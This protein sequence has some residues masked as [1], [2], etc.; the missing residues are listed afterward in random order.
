MMSNKEVKKILVV[1]DEKSLRLVLS[2]ILKNEGYDVTT[3]NDGKEALKVFRKGSF[4]LVT[5]CIMMPYPNTDGLTLLR[6]IKKISPHTPVLIISA[7]ASSKR[8]E[9]M[10]EGACG[11]LK[12]PVT[13]DELR[14]AVR[15][16]LK[17]RVKKT[18]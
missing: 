5:T 7:I 3:A 18:I 6:K 8:E 13:G 2:T 14:N 10:K 1:D 9:A 15:K 11:C 17:K 16:A 4:D 12:K